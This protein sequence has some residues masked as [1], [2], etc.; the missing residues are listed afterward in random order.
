MK[1]KI[2]PIVGILTPTLMEQVK[3]A[4]ITEMG[5]ELLAL[6][7][8]SLISWDIN[9]ETRE[10]TGELDIE[11]DEEEISEEDDTA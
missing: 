11:V 6:C 8:E 1:Y 4:L 2:D 7:D 5:I 9:Q 10:V 3:Y